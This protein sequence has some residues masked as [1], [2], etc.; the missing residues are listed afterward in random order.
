[1]KA[2]LINSAERT[3]TEVDY[4][5]SEQLRKLVGGW[6]E[7]AY[8]WPS[9]DVLYVD[10]EG[11]MKP[12]AHFFRITVRP[13][14]PMVGNGVIIGP[15]RDTDE[16]PEGFVTDPPSLTVEQVRAMVEFRN[17]DQFDAWAKANASDA[18]VTFTTLGPNGRV[19]T[20]TIASVRELFG[21]VPR[22]EED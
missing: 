18:A 1:M 10:E 17:R 15:E 20:E 16:V 11:L 6:I 9:K 7:L 14:Q 4:D 22:P 3:I 19:E 13:D 2:I 12:Q 21:S 8:M 5:G